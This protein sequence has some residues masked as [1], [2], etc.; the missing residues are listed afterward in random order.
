MPDLPVD[1]EKKVRESISPDGT[2]YPYRI[3]AKDLM[4]D[5]VF[6]AL[7]ASKETH[8]SGLKLEEE[9]DYG[10]GGH[11]KRI[12]K[13]AGTLTGGSGTSGKNLNMTIRHLAYDNNGNVYDPATPDVIAYFRDGLYVGTTDPADSPAQ[14]DQLIVTR[15]D[16][17]P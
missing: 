11:Q 16:S 4:Q 2:G 1:F 14:L 17:A 10:Q 12:I 8:S 15:L 5:F 3:S 9:T 6:A 13:I 7:E